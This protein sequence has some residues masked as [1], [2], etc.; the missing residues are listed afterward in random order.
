VNA[1]TIPIKR[2]VWR[3]IQAL[4]GA[5]AYVTDTHPKQRSFIM[6]R[7]PRIAVL[8]GRRGGKSHALAR[9]LLAAGERHPGSISVYVTLTRGKARQILWDLCLAQ[10]NTKHRLGLRIGELA[11]LLYIFQPNG[12]RIWLVGVDD[13]GE[14][15]KLRGP[16]YSE[17]VIDEAMAMP[18]YLAGL[19]QDAAEP[20]L[21]DMQGSCVLAGT[22]AALMAG[23]FWAATTGGDPEIEQW[24]THH[25]T[26]RDNPFIEWGEQY[27]D[28]EHYLGDK[29]KRDYG[30]DVE[31]PTYRREWLGHWVE[32]I[33]ALVYP[34]SYK[35]NSW[36]PVGDEN[37][38]LPPGEYTFGMGVDIGFTE[39]STAFTLGAQRKKTGQIYLLRSWVDSRL[40]PTALAAKCQAVRDEV[41]RATKTLERP[42]GLPLRI[43]VDEGALGKGFA[44]QMRAMGVGCEAAVKSEKRAYQEYVGGL[45]R[46]SSP[47]YQRMEPCARCSG[48]DKGCPVCSGCGEVNTGI[49]EGGFGVLVDF[50]ACGELIAEARKL[51]FD[52]ET[53]KESERYRKHACDSALYLI[54]SMMPG[55]VPEVLPPPPGT[56]EAIRLEMKA[57]KEREIKKRE[58][59]RGPG[60]Y[61]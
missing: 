61:G 42:K 25:F 15:E 56:P 3:K 59:A 2:S 36:T 46:S 38:G 7:R 13:R 60:R 57:L 31:H 34:F 47:P 9:R 35:G 17:V 20:G 55:Y 41:A 58:K 4:G 10:L 40:I 1:A 54:R 48:A 45:I 28:V 52:E 24:P 11:G 44:E 21:V 16:K 50:S 19:V 27:R 12:S 22:P 43:V 8:G 37:F 14:V 32:D 18:D 33:G 51:Q 26:I 39:R 6:D 29:L 30:G 49:W 23:Y 53:G 5:A